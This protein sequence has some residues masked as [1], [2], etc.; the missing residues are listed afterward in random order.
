MWY[1]DELVYMLFDEYDLT[2]DESTFWR[3]L[4][5]LGW[6][7][8]QMRRIAS[9]RNIFLRQSWFAALADWRAD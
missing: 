7:R 3:A 4:Q 8:K 5:R 1:L 6:S 2:V 9:Q